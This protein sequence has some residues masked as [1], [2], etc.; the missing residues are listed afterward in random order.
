MRPKF[1]APTIAMVV[2]GCDAPNKPTLS[3]PQTT[4]QEEEAHFYRTVTAGKM[5]SDLQTFLGSQYATPRTFA[6]DRLEFHR[7]SSVIAPPDRPTIDTLAATLQNY[8]EARARI[9]GYGDGNRSGDSS[10]G[11]K[12]ARAVVSALGDA[13][14]PSSRLEA[15]GGRESN[16]PRPAQ[17]IILQ[18]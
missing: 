6:F 3:E 17:L 2:L 9:V 4:R 14:V 13:G 5:L 1:L 16:K 15:A 8:P 11:L 7:G 10:L 18:K 12:R